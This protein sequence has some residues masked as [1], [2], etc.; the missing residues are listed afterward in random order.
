M[1]APELID[2][3]LVTPKP[4]P[5]GDE[6]PAPVP[7]GVMRHQAKAVERRRAAN[8]RADKAR[9]AQRPAKARR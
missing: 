4:Y 7:D 1:Q 3:K 2:G 6:P 5:K 9:R 8:K